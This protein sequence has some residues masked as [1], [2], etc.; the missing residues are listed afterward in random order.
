MPRVLCQ[1]CQRPEKACICDYIVPLSNAVKVVILQHP[2]EVTQVKGTVSLLSRSLQNCQVLVGEDFSADH[3]LSQVLNDYHCLLLYPSENAETLDFSY[4]KSLEKLKSKQS[5]VG[6]FT[7]K[8]CLI[9]LDGTWKKAYRMFMLSTNLQGIKHVCLPESIASQGQ[10]LIRKVAKE[11]AL[12]SLEA[13]CYALAILEQT[14]SQ[15]ADNDS[16][17]GS[18]QQLLE[19]FAQFNAFQLSF[20]PQSHIKNNN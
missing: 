6:E 18:Y 20:R 16:E 14:D 9:L 3:A 19:K 8:L 1:Q 7:D 11:N 4:V 5:Q 12:S 17:A 2:S 10:Y 13:C 15:R